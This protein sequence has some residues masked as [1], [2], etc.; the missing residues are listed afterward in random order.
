MKRAV[1]LVEP[2]GCRVRP[3]IQDFPDFR[4]GKRVYGPAEIRT[5]IQGSF[6]GGGAGYMAWDPR[7]EYTKEVYFQNAIDMSLSDDY[8]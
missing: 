5:Q 3:W 7:V 4:L 8:N 2:L 1:H 6:D